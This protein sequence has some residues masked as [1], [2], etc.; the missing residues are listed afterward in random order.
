MEKSKAGE[1][2]IKTN[3]GF[4]CV[5]QY[6]QSSRRRRYVHFLNDSRIPVK[7]MLIFKGSPGVDGTKTAGAYLYLIDQDQTVQILTFLFSPSITTSW[8]NRG[9]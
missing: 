4:C 8:P 2:K 3:E 7:K 6:Y 1:R 9:Q 5:M